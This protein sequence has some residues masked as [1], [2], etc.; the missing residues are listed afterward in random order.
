MELSKKEKKDGAHLGK[1]NC[2]IRGWSASLHY[3]PCLCYWLLCDMCQ[4]WP[5]VFLKLSPVLTS[6][7][8]LLHLSPLASQNFTSQSSSQYPLHYQWA[9]LS[10]VLTMVGIAATLCELL[11]KS[12]LGLN[13]LHHLK[14]HGSMVRLQDAL[15]SQRVTWASEWANNLCRALQ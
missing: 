1:E 5:T 6:L 15:C 9:C 7:S 12:I 8:T 14:A 3:A 4:G 13:V 2:G 10:L 11:F